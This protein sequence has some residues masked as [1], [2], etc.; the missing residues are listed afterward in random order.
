MLDEVGCDLFGPRTAQYKRFRQRIQALLHRDEG[1]F[2]HAEQNVL[3]ALFRPLQIF[4][5]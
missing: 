1:R 4:I 2:F 3:L 5:R